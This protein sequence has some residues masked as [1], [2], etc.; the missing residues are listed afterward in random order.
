MKKILSALL[1]IAAAISFVSHVAAEENFT[2]Q[3]ISVL[4]D[5]VNVRLDGQDVYIKNFVYNSS[6]YIGLRSAGETFGY[7]VSWDDQTRCASLVSGA[8]PVVNTDKKDNLSVASETISVLVDYAHIKIDGIESSVRNFDYN[9]T[10]YI[11]LRDIGNLFGYEVLWDEETRCASLNVKTL[12]YENISYTIN[13]I[14][15]P[16][17]V[18]KVLGQQYLQE[19]YSK[20]IAQNMIKNYALS[21]AFINETAKNLNISLSDNDIEEIN[22]KNEAII[23]QSGG[24]EIISIALKMS[25]ISLDEYKTFLY[26]VNCTDALYNKCSEYLSN[27]PAARKTDR[28]D[29]LKAYNEISDQLNKK[30]VLVKHILIPINND[31]DEKSAKETA[32]KLY[33]KAKSGANFDL[34]IKDN[35]NDPGMPDEGYYIY[36]G[37]G[38]VKEFETAALYLKPGEI[39]TPVK[40][41]FGYH[42]IKAYKTFDKIP[43]E[44][45]YGEY[46]VSNYIQTRFEEW[47]EKA[48]I[49]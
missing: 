20:D 6:T 5:Y 44:A 27:D 39:S 22:K 49:K 14:D 29:A 31:T 12:D 36:E 28:A 18:I 23:S 26:D 41:S 9:G 4:P 38:M 47:S 13:G 3:D 24:D 42:I 19:G 1:G 21:Y 43:F 33:E 46:D 40:T 30:T 48:E 25:N 45:F 17:E 11:S 35:N 8:E 7:T 32:D 16:K 10:L 2:R 34:L 15:L 37:S